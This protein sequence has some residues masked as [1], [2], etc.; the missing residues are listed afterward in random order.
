M[1]GIIFAVLSAISKGFEKILHKYVL[2]KEDSLSYAFIWHILSS[3]FFLPFFIIEFNLPKQHFAW[4]LVILSSILWAIVA[5]SGFKAYSH[6]EVSIKTPL[7]KSKMLFV[8]LFSV[9]FLKEILTLEKILGTILVFVGIIVLTYKKEK[10]FGDLKNKGGKL[11]LISAFL[12]SIVLL[13]DK[14]ATNF[15]NPGMYSFLVYFLPAIVI[16]P[17]VSNKKT[18]LKS[19][20]K[21]RFSTTITTTLLGAAY[22]Y[23]LLKAFKLAEASTVV[24]IVELSTLIAVFGGVKFLKESEEIPKK[25]I[26]TIIV[27]IGAIL[28]SGV[29][30]IP[31]FFIP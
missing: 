28:L 19:I 6:L 26:A 5:Y 1:L 13:V 9:I 23:L 17:F 14:Y 27:I 2:V 31:P 22:Y 11:T 15:F 30:K 24:P 16:F 3:I 20:F 21:N 25:I 4:M 8:L 18:E 10:R 29:F 7:G 12:M